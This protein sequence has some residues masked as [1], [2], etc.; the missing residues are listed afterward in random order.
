MLI[1]AAIMDGKRE[2][3]GE[4]R[5]VVAGRPLDMLVVP[6]AVMREWSTHAHYIS[7]Q[8]AL[9]TQI[10]LESIL[11]SRSTLIKALLSKTTSY[12]DMDKP[13]GRIW[14]RRS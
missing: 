12:L 1:V 11:Q 10:P 4:G 5:L 6:E 13:G 3:G 7:N 9:L 2:E 14:C 8:M